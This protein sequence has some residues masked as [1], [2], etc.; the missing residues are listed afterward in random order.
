MTDGCTILALLAA[1]AFVGWIL[2]RDAM[3]DR[4]GVRRFQIALTR[5]QGAYDFQLE[6]QPAGREDQP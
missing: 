2:Y 3:R 4:D 6:H 5:A 1:A